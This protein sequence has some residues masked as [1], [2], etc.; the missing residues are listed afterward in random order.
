MSKI[1]LLKASPLYNVFTY[2][3]YADNPGLELKSYNEQFRVLMDA[4]FWEADFWSKNLNKTGKYEAVDVLVNAPALQKQWAKENNAPYSAANW[5]QDILEAQIAEF[6]PDIFFAQ[7]FPDIDAGFKH[8]LKKKYPFLK[9]IL[10]WDG[11]AHRNPEK[12]GGSDIVMTPAEFITQAYTDAGVEAFTLPFGFEKSL[13][14][15]IEQGRNKYPVSFV[16]GISLFKNAHYTRLEVLRQVNRAMPVDLFLSG[17]GGWK[18]F[19]VSAY[20]TFT[21]GRFSD[22][23]KAMSLESKNKGSL[24]GLEMYQAL[25][26]SKITLNIHIDR[27]GEHAANI[28]LFEA[29]GAGTCLLTDWKENLSQFFEPGKEVVTFKTPEECV[30]KAKWL[31]EHE[32]ERK[33][34]AA[35]GQKRTLEQYSFEKRMAVFAEKMEAFLAARF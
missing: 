28:R 26:D 29:T 12:F 2:K 5:I 16:G 33:T 11:I 31:L 23:F 15:K 30:E 24:F 32:T 34:I 3:I 27:A 21:Q 25:A 1:R 22:F 10:A 6:K 13:L 8:R 19:L 4:C 20:Q 18:M 14:D 9:I 7:D 17:L 35:A